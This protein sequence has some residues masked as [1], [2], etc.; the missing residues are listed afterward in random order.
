M[1]RKRKKKEEEAAET[2]GIWRLEEHVTQAI[3]AMLFFILASFFLLS[4]FDLAGVAG[5]HTYRVLEMLFGF[6][7]FLLPLSMLF[8]SIAFW[9][10]IEVDFAISK[11]LGITLFFVSGLGIINIATGEQ[12]GLIGNIISSPLLSA[13]DFYITYLQH[14]HS[15]RN[16]YWEVC[17]ASQRVRL[18]HSVASWPRDDH[19]L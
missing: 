7:Y 5:G 13:F 11:I 1:A 19:L 17:I 18:N 8:L 9:R 16:Y 6:G 2:L 15:P 14:H 3:L 10:K 4:G 12:G